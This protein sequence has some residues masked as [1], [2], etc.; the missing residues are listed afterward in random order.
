MHRSLKVLDEVRG[1]LDERRREVPLPTKA[2]ALYVEPTARKEGRSCRNCVM[3]SRTDQ[4]LIHEPS[5]HI[6]GDY[7]CGYHSPGEPM[8]ALPDRKREYVSPGL[9]GLVL[10]PGGTYCGVCRWAE[11][12]KCRALQEHG[13]PAAIEEYSCCAR[14]AAR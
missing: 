13:E 12:G 11:N 7:V 3:W 5:L 4:C 8:E 9:S 10:V 1:L 14:W 6:S 2:E